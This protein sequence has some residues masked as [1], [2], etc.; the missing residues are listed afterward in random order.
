MRASL[1]LSVAAAMSW[2]AAGAAPAPERATL[3][4][5]Q[6]EL[7]RVVE[8]GGLEVVDQEGGSVGSSEYLTLSLAQGRLSHLVISTQRD[9]LIVVP[10]GSVRIDEGAP[11]IVLGATTEQIENA[12][13]LTRDQLATLAQPAV[14]SHV[15]EYWA[16]ASEVAAL[17]GGPPGAEGE[18]PAAGAGQPHDEQDPLVPAG[19]EI[20]V[21]ITAPVLEVDEALR[22]ATVYA[23]QGRA[24]G[25]IGEIV[26]DPEAGAVAFVVIEGERGRAAVPLQ[27]L[28]WTA[29][30]AVVLR[31]DPGLLRRDR[32]LLEQD[33]VDRQTLVQ[34]Y[35]RFDVPAPW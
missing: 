34:L 4:P 27:V 17:E 7:V 19:S 26:I 22:G 23:D 31:A 11:P 33:L 8:L 6:I 28:S 15:R 25:S 5:D 10:W 21:A 9:D 1:L 35:E 2:V 30:D 13:R 14:A 3:D 24:V 29:A 32:G 12:P 16:P 18:A 20:V